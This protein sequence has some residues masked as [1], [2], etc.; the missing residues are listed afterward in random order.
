MVFT[1]KMWFPISFAPLV[2]L[3]GK[4]TEFCWFNRILLVVAPLR[5]QR[6]C[7]RFPSVL[8]CPPGNSEP[9][10]QRLSPQGKEPK[11][12]SSSPK[13]RQALPLWGCRQDNY[14]GFA[15]CFILLFSIPP[16]GG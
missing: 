3:K 13:G 4:A 2:A 15:L 12:A 8:L 5:G 6:S 9:E 7:L 10:G 14:V 11:G 16:R 1:E